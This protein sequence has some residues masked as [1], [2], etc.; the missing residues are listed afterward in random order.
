V[1][2]NHSCSGE[3]GEKNSP[4]CT[5]T[6]RTLRSSNAKR[7]QFARVRKK[8]THS[9]AVLGATRRPRGWRGQ[10]PRRASPG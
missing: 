2:P 6:I 8:C 10:T 5:Y 1:G 9:V 3:W 4:E 7:Y